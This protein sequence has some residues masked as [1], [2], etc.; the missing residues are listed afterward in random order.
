ML[1]KEDV[2]TQL[3]KCFILKAYWLEKLFLN[4]LTKNFPHSLNR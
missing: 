1:V 3:D 4:D 2:K